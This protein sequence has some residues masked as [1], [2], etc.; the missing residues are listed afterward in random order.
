M[1]SMT[2]EEADAL[3]TY[4]TEH[5]IMPDINKPGYFARK[6]GMNVQLDPETTSNVI[7]WAET[8][9]RTPAQV[10]GDLVRRELA[11]AATA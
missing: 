5:D 4:F 2:E 8:E 1:N 7:K 11:T 6:Y 10:I 3:D 9:H